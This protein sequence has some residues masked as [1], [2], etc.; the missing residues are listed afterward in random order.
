QKTKS[1][2]SA[3]PMRASGLRRSAL[4]R[5]TTPRKP[6]EGLN[7]APAIFFFELVIGVS[8]LADARVEGGVDE[9]GEEVDGDIGE[10]DGEQASLDEGVVAVA[11]GADGEASDAGP[12][13][14]GFGDDGTGEEGSELESE[15]GDDRD[16]GVAQSM[17]ID[18]AALGE[19]LG[20]SGADVVL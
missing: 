4:V 6:E 5:S 10:A 16:E 12:G 19:S 2:I 20:A 1:R 15:D 11:D 8:S 7:G 3:E 17:A 18:Y 13:E 14:D 9:V